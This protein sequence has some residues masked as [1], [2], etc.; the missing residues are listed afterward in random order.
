M[1]K[2]NDDEKKKTLQKRQC[3]QEDIVMKGNINPQQ[4][5][6]LLRKQQHQH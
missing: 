5:T 3:T 2:S 4:T 6:K 1:S